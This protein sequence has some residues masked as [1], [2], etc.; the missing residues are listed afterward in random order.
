MTQLTD[1]GLV[2]EEWGGDTIFRQVSAKQGLHLDE[3]L[4][5]I[6][7]VA[8]M[9]ELKANPKRYALGTVVEAK[10]DKDQLQPF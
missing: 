9:A 7:L 5:T 3:L 1:L 6:L 2:P 10:L 8:E 4:E